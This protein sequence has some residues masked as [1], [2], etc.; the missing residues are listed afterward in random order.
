[1]LQRRISLSDSLQLQEITEEL[2]VMHCLQGLAQF[3]VAIHMQ[4][5]GSVSISLDLLDDGCMQ[6]GN[7]H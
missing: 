4:L 2:L 1:M 7:F 5:V 6:C 3:G